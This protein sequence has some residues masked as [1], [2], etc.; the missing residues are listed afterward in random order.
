MVL[1]VRAVGFDVDDTLIDHAGAARQGLDAHLASSGL[2]VDEATWRRWLAVEHLHFDRYLAGELSFDGQRRARARDFTGS[3]FSDGEADAWFD[4]Y[5]R[6]LEAAW[7]VFPDVL[8][9][10]DQL[11][12]A[13]VRLGAFSNV[14]GTYTRRKLAAV[15]LLDRFAVA[16]GR[17]DVRTGKPSAEPFLTLAARL[18][19][20]P[21]ATLHVGDRYEVDARPARA[22]GLQ[23][24]WLRRPT[25]DPSRRDPEGPVDRAVV[26]ISDLAELPSLVDGLVRGGFGADQPLR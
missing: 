22:A 21:R 25:A 10:L 15:G 16:L 3:A 2:A 17:D 6:C 12:S 23:S 20:E 8:P 4:G 24:V 5:R 11:A 9:A 19:V 13:G 7:T 1:V 14:D 26:T 18:G